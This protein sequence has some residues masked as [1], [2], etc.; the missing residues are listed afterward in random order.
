LATVAA[1]SGGAGAAQLGRELLRDLIGGEPGQLQ[2]RRPGEAGD[3]GKGVAAARSLPQFVRAE[4]ADQ[5]QRCAL[6]ATGQVAEQEQRGRVRPVQVVDHDHQATGGHSGDELRHLVEQDEALLGGGRRQLG[7]RSGEPAELRH[8]PGDPVDGVAQHLGG[9]GRLGFGQPLPEDLPPRPVRRRTLLRDALASENPDAAAELIQQRALPYAGGA[10]Q[11][12]HRRPARQRLG[13]PLPEQGQFVPTADQHRGVRIG[14]AVLQLLAVTEN[15]ELQPPKLGPGVDAELL[16]QVRPGPAEDVQRLARPAAPVQRQ[17]QLPDQ[18][19]P[20]R[21]GVDEA[22]QLLDDVP[23]P[24]QLEQGIHPILDRDQARLLDTRGEHVAR[25]IRSHVG[26]D[27]APP[28]AQ[29]LVEHLQARPVVGRLPGLCDQGE[30]PV[31]V[32]LHRV[33]AEEVS[34]PV[35]LDLHGQPGTQVG[36]GNPDRV[37]SGARRGLGPDHADQPVDGHQPV[38][39][40]GQHAE[41]QPPLPRSERHELVANL[42]FDRAQHPDLHTVRLPHLSED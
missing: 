5:Q 20:G 3:L 21:V 30:K 28:Q 33:A 32:D 38:G 14:D 42:G 41:H 16:G 35:R 39:L 37:R 9:H 22:Q 24:A 7:L 13:P 34:G 25:P 29:R 17:H 23:M 2:S 31:H 11:Q 26:H 12:H 15:R 1:S 10:L 40:P 27:R 36:D 18:P 8:Y 4:R 19:F 6:G